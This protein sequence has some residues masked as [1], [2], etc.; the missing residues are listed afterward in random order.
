WRLLDHVGE[1]ALVHFRHPAAGMT[2]RQIAAKQL[3][4][5]VGGPRLAR[6]DLEMGVPAKQL[7]LGR[8]GLELAGKHADRNAG[9]AVNAARAVGDRL[10]AAEADAAEGLVQFAGVAPVELSEHLPLDL[11]R[12]VRTRARVRYEE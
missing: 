12:Q 10:T 4:L 1:I 8:A 7:A 3:I 5:L 9:R 11:A 6:A 2:L